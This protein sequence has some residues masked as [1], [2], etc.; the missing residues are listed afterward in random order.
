VKGQVSP[1]TQ[2]KISLD[3]GGQLVLGVMAM[4]TVDVSLL[5][6]CLFH[7]YEPGSHS[8]ISYI[9]S[10]SVYKVAIVIFI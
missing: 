8:L 9:H 7:L 4:I 5:S 3:S 10:F 1:K 6:I 2:P